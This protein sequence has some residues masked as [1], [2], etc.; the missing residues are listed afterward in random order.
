MHITMVNGTET[1]LLVVINRHTCVSLVTLCGCFTLL[2]I[3]Y[4]NI[5]LAIT[6]VTTLVVS[7]IFRVF[8]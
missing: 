6:Y 8:I 3:L 7:A 5:M 4:R 1:W 2:T